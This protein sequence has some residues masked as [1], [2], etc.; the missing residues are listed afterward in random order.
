MGKD[1]ENSKMAI[2]PNAKD[3]YSNR[4]RDF[5]IQNVLADMKNFGFQAS[6]VDLRE[7]HGGTRLHKVLMNYDILWISGGNSFVLRHEIRASGLEVVL[8]QLL[9]SGIVYA[10]ESAGA[11]VAGNSLRGV[12][13]ADEPEFAAEI[14]WDGLNLTNHFVLPHV[15]SAEFGSAIDRAKN[16]HQ[17]DTTMIQ[18]T[19][20][21][22]FIINNHQEFIVS[23]V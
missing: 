7:H 1:F 19:D 11:L 2:I 4:A 12:E 20:T 5:K 21:D 6:V 15:G 17:H 13:F 23:A 10:G 22:A 14:I 8:K 9:N 3:Y 16:M 18:L